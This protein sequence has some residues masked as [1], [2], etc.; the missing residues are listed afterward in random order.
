M[1][2]AVLEKAAKEQLDIA[3]ARAEG[4]N[5]KVVTIKA[6]A[7]DEGKLFGSLVRAMLLKRLSCP[8]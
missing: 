2:R 1:R 5:K 7:G 3:T 8:G 4:L 6:K